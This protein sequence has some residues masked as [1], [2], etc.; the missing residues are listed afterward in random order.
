[1]Y[2]AGAVAFA[3]ESALYGE[4]NLLSGYS[5][6]E[7][8]IGE[9]GRML[10][11]SVGFEWY[12]N[13]S[14]DF[15]D[16]LTA[17]LQARLSYDSSAD[18]EDEWAVEIH[19]AWLE[20]KLGLGR[21]LRLG[22]FSPAFGLESSLD[23]HGT[24]FQTL[25]G[26]DIGFKKDWGIGYRGI[27]GGF[28]YQVAAQL[29]SGMGIEQDDGSFLV[30]GRMGSPQADSFQYGLSLLYGEVLMGKQARIFPRP[31]MGEKATFKRRAGVDAQFLHGSL[32][33]KGELTL[34]RN[35]AND[36]VGAL[37]QLDY[38]VPS[39]QEF[40]VGLQG[41]VWS[42]DPSDNDAAASEVGIRALYK[43]SRDLVLRLGLFQDVQ[44]PGDGEEV[45]I[46]VQLYYFGKAL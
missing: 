32:A 9:K 2:L 30:S 24:L 36:V 16:F 22:H 1:M 38:T 10:K 5:E 15:G 14:D 28:D 35:E 39:H 7:E 13:F 20:Y 34:G 25:A 46:F 42:D 45:R 3:D 18:A 31:D 6:S 4:V 41:R 27:L 19:N 8:W 26:Q 37:V 11:N 12:G 29:G 21:N 43:V 33:Y 40:G 17:D 23:T 44:R